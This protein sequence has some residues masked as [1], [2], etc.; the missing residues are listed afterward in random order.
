MTIPKIIHQTWKSKELTPY[1]KKASNSWKRMNP[2]YTYRFYDDTDCLEFITKNY[3][4]YLKLY[5]DLYLPVQKADLFRYLVIYHNG[6]YYTDIDTTCIKPLRRLGTRDDTCIVGIDEIKGSKGKK[7]KRARKEYLQWFFGAEAKHP[8]LLEVVKV[9]QERMDKQPCT[10]KLS[11]DDRYTLWLT[12][13]RA[14]TEGLKRFS[15][16]YPKKPITVKDMCYF[17]STNAF[18]NKDCLN[19][20]FLLHHYDGSWKNQWKAGSKKWF[21]PAKL[22]TIEGFSEHDNHE[23]DL[24]W[25]D[26][27]YFI[28][29][30][31]VIVATETIYDS[32]QK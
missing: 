29:L 30:L 3:P 17:G 10:K 7:H 24:N 31:A 23:G 28:A 27:T 11:E 5:K 15:D 12:G 20:A 25:A 21:M 22:P 18:Y 4:N 19:K 13:P 9:I 2:N 6:G 8:A 26:T 1:F 32:L 16:K 14:F